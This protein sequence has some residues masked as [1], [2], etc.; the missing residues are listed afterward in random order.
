MHRGIFSRCYSRKQKQS[1]GR[2]RSILIDYAACRSDPQA[3]RQC[4]GSP[5]SNLKLTARKDEQW[6][7][8]RDGLCAGLKIQRT[9]F[10][11]SLIH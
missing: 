3:A 9:R 4:F 10:E 2:G 8:S 7:G 5:K 1:E 11:S 6:M